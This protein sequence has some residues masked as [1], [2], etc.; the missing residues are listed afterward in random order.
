MF[1]SRVYERWNN[2]L[3][4]SCFISKILMRTNPLVFARPMAPDNTSFDGQPW[5][6]VSDVKVPYW[7]AQPWGIGVLA[8]KHTHAWLP[9]YTS[10]FSFASDESI[11]AIHRLTFAALYQ[12]CVWCLSLVFAVHRWHL[13]RCKEGMHIYIHVY[14]Y[15]YTYISLCM[16]YAVNN[17]AG[18]SM[19]FSF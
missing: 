9:L 10:A 11:R 17:R 4:I 1:L 18:N 3:V 2:Y 8:S 13:Y 12:H 15:I 5:N 16:H 14:I 7:G 6:G 19:Q